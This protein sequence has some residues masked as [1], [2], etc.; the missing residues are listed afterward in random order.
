VTVTGASPGLGRGNGRSRSCS[1]RYA[2]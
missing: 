1:S 2:R